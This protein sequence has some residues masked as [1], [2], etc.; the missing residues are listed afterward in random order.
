MLTKLASEVKT[1]QICFISK[2]FHCYLATNY[3]H[4]LSIFVSLAPLSQNVLINVAEKIIVIIYVLTQCCKRFIK[5]V[6]RIM[7]HYGDSQA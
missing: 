4:C 1:K 3:N 5:I 7:L 6:H 2:M